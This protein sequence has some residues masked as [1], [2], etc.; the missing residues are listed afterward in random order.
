MNPQAGYSNF[1]ELYPLL[2]EAGKQRS[3]R[4]AAPQKQYCST[5]ST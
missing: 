1:T 3:F 2:P 4:F 5:D